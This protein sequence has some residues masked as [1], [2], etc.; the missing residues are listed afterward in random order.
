MLEEVFEF[1]KETLPTVD[2]ADGKNLISKGILDSLAIISIVMGI[3]EKYGIS[4][5]V[6]DISVENFDSVEKIAEMIE[7]KKSDA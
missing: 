5:D 1:L 6:E 4:V 3:V 7:R 2:F